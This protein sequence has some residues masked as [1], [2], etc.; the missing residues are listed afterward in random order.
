VYKIFIPFGLYWYFIL[1]IILT[2]IFAITFLNN[3]RPLIAAI[4]MSMDAGLKIIFSVII[5]RFTIKIPPLLRGKMSLLIKVFLLIFWMVALYDIMTVKNIVIVMLFFLIFKFIFLMDTII[6]SEFIFIM[7]KHFHLELSQI[8]AAQNILVRAVTFFAPAAALIFFQNPV[9]YPILCVS[10]VL[11]SIFSIILLKEI[12]FP[13]I[14]YS[15]HLSRNSLSFRALIA[16]P[17]MRWALFYQIISNLSFGGVAL[18]FLSQLKVNGSIFLNEITALY[19]AFLIAQSMVLFFG[20]RWVPAKK[21]SHIGIILA[22]CGFF[23]LMASMMHSNEAR[24]IMCIFIGI[25]YSFTLS[26]L[27]KMVTTQLQGMQFVGYT[28][29]MQTAG[30]FSSLISTILLSV[31]LSKGILSTDLLTAC[32]ILGIIGGILLNVLNYS[33]NPLKYSDTN[34]SCPLEDG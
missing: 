1:D 20:E 2:H 33:W 6:S 24:L 34:N 9:V 22:T 11:M 3:A 13:S 12:F 15:M 29:W 7:R 28:G 8:S 16:N 31:L 26:A 25:M 14:E 19:F 4:A 17:L 10:A 5:S 21:I 18:L 23:I 30:R 32:G 27:Q